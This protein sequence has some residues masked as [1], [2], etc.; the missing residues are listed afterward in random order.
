MKKNLLLLN[1]L[2]FSVLICFPSCSDNSDENDEKGDLVGRWVANSI[3]EWGERPGSTTREDYGKEIFTTTFTFNAN[4]TGSK[5]EEDGERIDFEWRYDAET[6]KLYLESDDDD[7]Y[8]DITVR[9]TWQSG[10]KITLLEQ[11]YD[12]YEGYYWYTQ[13][14]C[15]RK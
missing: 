2:L 3:E 6:G 5:V 11:Y 15:K 9:I 12:T 13:Y 8:D 10:S 1:A 4:R 7:Y 14:T